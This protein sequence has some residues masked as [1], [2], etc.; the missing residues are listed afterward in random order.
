M[1]LNSA[2]LA[3]R[4]RAAQAAKGAPPSQAEQMRM[5]RADLTLLQ[6]TV[7]D[8]RHALQDCVRIADDASDTLDKDA[9]DPTLAIWQISREAKRALRHEEQGTPLEADETACPI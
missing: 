2:G 1:T 7:V 8:Y 5:L 9:P 3:F 4:R 6:R